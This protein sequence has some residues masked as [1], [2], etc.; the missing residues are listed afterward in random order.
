MDVESIVAWALPSLGLLLWA[1]VLAV[2]L[3]RVLARFLEPGRTHILALVGLYAALFAA[4][5]WLWA[6]AMPFGPT[7]RAYVTDELEPWFWGTLA[8]VAFVIVSFFLLRRVLRFLADKAATTHSNVDDAVVLAVRRPAHVLILFAAFALWI[9]IVPAPDALSSQL[10]VVGQVVLILVIA[11][12]A[13]GALMAIF[14]RRKETSRV[15]AT[16]GGVL[17]AMT[18]VVLFVIVGLMILDT[19]GVAVTP[20]VASL[21][22]GSL[23]IG[24]ALQSTLEDFISGLLIAADQPVTIGDFVELGERSLAG[25]VVRIGWRTTRIE[26]LERVRVIVP[27]SVLAR[28]TLINRSRP[29]PVLRFQAEV[30]VHYHSDLRHVARVVQE[31]ALAV[32][33]SHPQATA[34]FTPTVIFVAFGDSSIDLK[35]WLEATDWVN[36]FGVHDAFIKQLHERF[37]QEG[38]V[39]PFPIRT[40]DVPP[41][42]QRALERLGSHP[43]V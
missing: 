27:N 36:H 2:A 12:F 17:R 20:V 13:D 29:S 34:D 22:I 38:I 25:T 18:R 32:Q 23:A 21:G 24:L 43:R 39:I 11:L 1:I 10:G 3:P 14:E 33:K 6:L 31:V 35:V 19:I 26:T 4:G 15:F 9:E 40:L 41:A 30:G 16:A 37:K 5:L 7:T 28:A 42:L 8:L